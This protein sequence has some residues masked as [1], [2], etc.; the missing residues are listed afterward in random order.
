MHRLGTEQAFVALG[1]TR[2]LDSVELA[3]G[4]RNCVPPALAS[5]SM[6]NGALLTATT[7]TAI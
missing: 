6:G 3:T 4:R 1:M 5:S 7:D 2:V